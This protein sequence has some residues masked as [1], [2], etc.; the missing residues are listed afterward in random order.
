MNG[1]FVSLVAVAAFVAS[2]SPVAPDPPQP[3]KSPSQGGVRIVKA[4]CLPTKAKPADVTPSK[5]VTDTYRILLGSVELVG[6]DSAIVKGKDGSLRVPLQAFELY[7]DG[8]LVFEIS[9]YR[10]KKLVS[11]QYSK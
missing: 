10:F 6:P 2:A 4:I 1:A 5:S 9:P 8:S 3:Q 7:C 11:E